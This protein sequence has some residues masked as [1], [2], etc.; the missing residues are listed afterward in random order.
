MVKAT[1]TE[2][3]GNQLVVAKRIAEILPHQLIYVMDANTS[4]VP[5]RLFKNINVATLGDAP[6]KIISV[7][8]K[9]SVDPVNAMSIYKDRLNKERKFY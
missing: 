5:V 6:S 2:K 8:V 1:Q 4:K 3:S 7:Q 9:I